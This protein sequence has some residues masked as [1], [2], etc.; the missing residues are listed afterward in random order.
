MDLVVEGMLDL[1]SFSLKVSIDYRA[2]MQDIN[3]RVM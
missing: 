1:F 3:K 2:P